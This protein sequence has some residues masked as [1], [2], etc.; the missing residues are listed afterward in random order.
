MGIQTWDYHDQESSLGASAV[1]PYQFKL[2]EG[3][4]PV[5]LITLRWAVGLFK[6]IAWGMWCGGR[7]NCGKGVMVIH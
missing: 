7:H 3:F 5:D 2:S 6:Q 4:C 1:E